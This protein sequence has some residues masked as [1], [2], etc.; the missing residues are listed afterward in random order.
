LKKTCPSILKCHIYCGGNSET[1]EVGMFTII[2]KAVLGMALLR[3]LSGVIEIL[4]AA[5]MIR[6]NTIEKAIMI[7]S[8]LAIIGPLI[9][10]FTTT[11][12]LFGFIENISFIRLF[13]IF[14]GVGF[15]LFGV[16]S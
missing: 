14:L 12:G 6:F 4:A 7:N 15:I 10:I 5:L 16:K 9:F 13:W 1:Q 8:S 2:E 11:I 3:L